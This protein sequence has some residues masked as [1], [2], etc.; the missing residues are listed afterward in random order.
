MTV[1]SSIGTAA[2]AA[3]VVACS[4][5]SRVSVTT[6]TSLDP[7]SFSGPFTALVNGTAGNQG[8]PHF[9]TQFGV[10]QSSTTVNGATG[11]A[12]ASVSGGIDP[13]MSASIASGAA[14][15][16]HDPTGT[17]AA[18]TADVYLRYQFDFNG[19]ATSVPMIVNANGS[20]TSTGGGSSSAALSIT[21]NGVNINY[22]L[23]CAGAPGNPICSPPVSTPQTAPFFTNS[24]YT[25]I[26]TITLDGGAAGGQP[27]D[28]NQTMS[29]FIDPMFTIDLANASDFT[30][31]FSS[32]LIPPASG[33][34]LP[35]AL[36]LFASGL[37][38]LGLLARRRKRKAAAVAA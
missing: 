17:G 38:A 31:D 12:N 15:L 7:V 6:A 28:Q 10:Y 2:L 9:I 36:P 35:A 27:T 33:T 14:S 29:G 19:P 22:N 1:Q 3:G 30:F 5:F 21:G 8:D 20:I 34:P 18:S 11:Q 4:F 24:V 23:G 16:A 13:A 37:A 32:G 25:V 26:M